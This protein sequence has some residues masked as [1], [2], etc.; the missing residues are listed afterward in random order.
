MRTDCLYLAEMGY[1]M[2]NGI[3][4]LCRQV[5]HCYRIPCAV[6]ANNVLYRYAELVALLL[7]CVLIVY[8]AGKGVDSKN[9]VEG[10]ALPHANRLVLNIYAVM[11]RMATASLSTHLFTNNPPRIFY[12]LFYFLLLVRFLCVVW[13]S[14]ASFSCILFLSAPFFAA[15]SIIFILSSVVR[16]SDNNCLR[17]SF[18]CLEFSVWKRTKPVACKFPHLIA[19]NQNNQMNAD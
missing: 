11:D 6:S 18:I 19:Y 10:P 12:P 15:S 13:L 5:L 17:M 1:G 9:G 2:E 14:C 3:N 4:A 7:K 8:L 16:V